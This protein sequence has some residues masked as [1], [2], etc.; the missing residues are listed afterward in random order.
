MANIIKVSEEDRNFVQRADLDASSMAN[1]LS[2]MMA[3]NIDIS[4]ERFTNYEEKYK[5]AF[6]NF[7]KAKNYIEKKYVTPLN[8][9]TSWSLDYETCEITYNV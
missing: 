5:Q 1:L 9:A 7:E 8:I 6:L 3:N 4:S 2:Y